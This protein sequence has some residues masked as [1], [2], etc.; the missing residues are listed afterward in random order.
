VRAYV[1]AGFGS[2]LT[3]A[4][5]AFIEQVGFHGPRQDVPVERDAAALLAN[6]LGRATTTG[7]S[8]RSCVAIADPECRNLVISTMRVLDA[9]ARLGA[10]DRVVVEIGNEPNLKVSAADYSEALRAIVILCQRWPNVEIV[11]GGIS[12]VGDRE[13]AWLDA[14]LGPLDVFLL[15]NAPKLGVAFHSYRDGRSDTPRPG[16]RSRGEE[17]EVLRIKARGRPLYHTEGGWSMVRRRRWPFF[18]LWRGLGAR[19]VGARWQEELRL[20]AAH[21]VRTACVYQINDGPTNTPDNRFG[22]RDYRGV[23]KESSAMLAAVL[24]L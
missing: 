24:P 4:T 8:P 23:P 21:D 5:L 9:V 6:A 18:W 1:N 22:L 3:Q 11:T 14:V 20:L 17:M 7:P 10:Q 2:P 13:L 16:F 19:E 15:A 12:N